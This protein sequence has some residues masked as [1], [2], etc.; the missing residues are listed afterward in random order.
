M[1]KEDFKEVLIPIHGRFWQRAYKKLASKMSALKSSLKRRS[2]KSG[3]VF[4]IDLLDLKKMFLDVYGSECKYCSKI[5]TYKNIACDHIIP[6]AKSGKSVISNLQLICRTCNT[7]KG[8][9]NEKDFSLLVDL[10]FEL[11]DE[12]SEYVMRKLAKGGRY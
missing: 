4:D 10:V 2:I 8:P 3:V 11:P 5:L 9:L 1:K 12:L 7:R 6:L